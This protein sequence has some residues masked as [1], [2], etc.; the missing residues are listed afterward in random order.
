MV[1]CKTLWKSNLNTSSTSCNSVL[2]PINEITFRMR[3]VILF[4]S[5]TD[6]QM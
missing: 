4:V 1:A 6:N 3:Q 5:L 2:M